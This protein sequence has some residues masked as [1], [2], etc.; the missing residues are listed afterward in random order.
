MVKKTDSKREKNRKGRV[1]TVILV[2]FL[3]WYF[4]N[5]SL[6]I[7]RTSTESA[8]ISEPVRIAVLSDLHVHNGSIS[9]S[10]I[11]RKIDEIS[12][13]AVFILGDMYSRKSDDEKIEAAID[14]MS[15]VA[16]KYTVYFVSGDHD[17]SPAYFER[18]QNRGVHVM[19]YACEYAEIK[20]TQ[21]KIMGIDNV[22]YSS[23]FDL[24]NAFTLDENSFN[25]V[26]AH[27]PNYRAF[28]KFGAD[29]TLSADTHGGMVRLP[30]LGALF[31]PLTDTYFP[32]LRGVK[33]YDKGWFEYDGGKLFITSGMGDS[34]I[35]VRFC[36][37]PEIVSIDLVPEND[38]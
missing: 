10:R 20:G 36:N 35:P 15:S 37:L 6:K 29:L 38:S 17:T 27:I 2:L 18:L 34:P 11:M 16:E 13:D 33:A 28:S 23:T 8:K 31:D 21:F 32:T 19:N 4:N 5:Y 22:Y 9:S 25:I 30:I 3:V 26:L 7:T 12:P 24:N 1:W 14:L